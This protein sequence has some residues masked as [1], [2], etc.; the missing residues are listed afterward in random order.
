VQEVIQKLDAAL[1]LPGVANSWT[2][3]IRSRIDML[4][5]GLR[6]P[7]GLKISGRNPQAIQQAGVQIEDV[8]RSVPGTRNVFAER[9]DDGLY[10]DVRWDRARLSSAGIG[11][12][13]AQAT[14][15]NSIGGDNVTT[16]IHDRARYPVNVRLP[17][18]FRANLDDL[19]NVL[20][21]PQEGRNAVPLG[22]V[23][24]AGISR[25]PAMIR[26]E[27]GLL[28]GYVYIDLAGRGPREYVAEA[29]SILRQRLQLPPECA[30]TWSGEYESIDRT[31]ARLW[32]IVPV[33]LACVALLLYWS[34]RSIAKTALVFLAVPFSAIGA[35]W[36]LYLLSYPMSPAVW[37]GFIAL[38]GVDAETGTFMLLYLDL[39]Y[40]KKLAS[41]RPLTSADLREATLAGAV[42]R[43]R[44]KFM[45]VLAMFAGLLP[46]LWSDGA[47]AEVMKRI[48]A[49]MVGGLA[50]SFLMELLVYPVLYEWWT[51]RTIL[52]SAFQ[53]VGRPAVALHG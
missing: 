3:P 51:S 38:F 40:Q 41:G 42:R 11:L 33:A 27:N 44:P 37:V 52:A 1:P 26:D 48:A 19:R 53:P 49:P 9:M 36:S 31:S 17:R 21:S 2:M 4:A 16:V 20:V 13:E 7:L 5:T 43:I 23:A 29:S 15:E 24:T 39:A 30:W 46:I 8:L 14:V 34:T 35:I 47:G 50:T 12:E 18:D 32:Q 6:S 28:T 22:Q 45:T 25:G 10:I